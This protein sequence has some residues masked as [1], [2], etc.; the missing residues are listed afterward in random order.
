MTDA[1]FSRTIVPTPSSL[2]SLA[3][4]SPLP[5]ARP[6]TAAA[7]SVAGSVDRL[8]ASVARLELLH[9]VRSTTREAEK[10]AR[11]MSR[12]GSGSFQRCLARIYDRWID[13]FAHR[14]RVIAIASAV[15][16]GVLTDDHVRIGAETLASVHDR[17]LHDLYWATVRR[18]RQSRR[19]R[20]HP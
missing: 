18:W 20:A 6:H 3:L 19:T 9:S 2:S 13:T 11:M 1:T 12:S 14:E 17:R 7:A 15:E 16:A 4:V 10:R 8:A 5:P